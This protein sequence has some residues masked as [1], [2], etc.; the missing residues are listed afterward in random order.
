MNALAIALLSGALQGD[1]SAD[2]DIVAYDNFTFAAR[3]G[4]RLDG[5][6]TPSPVD[7]VFRTDYIV[8]G[9]W[10]QIADQVRIHGPHWAAQVFIDGSQLEGEWSCSHHR[11]RIKLESFCL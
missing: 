3:V 9:T 5:R 11:G 10:D 1:V 2:V 7:D 6:G 4:E 8:R